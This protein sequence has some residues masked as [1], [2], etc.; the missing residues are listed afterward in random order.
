MARITA[1]TAAKTRSVTLPSACAASSNTCTVPPW[2]R[3]VRCTS[4]ATPLPDPNG[5]G[6][7]RA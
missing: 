4:R 6:A 5:V 2:L 1:L 7:T 3:L